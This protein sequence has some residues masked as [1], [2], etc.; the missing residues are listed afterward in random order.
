MEK[1]LNHKSL[2]SIALTQYQIDEIQLL[3]DKLGSVDMRRLPDFLIYSDHDLSISERYIKSRQIGC[4]VTLEKFQ[5]R[6][7][8]QHGTFRWE[9]YKKRQSYTNTLEYKEKI[10]GFTKDDFDEYNKGRAVTE[11]NLIK[12]YGEDI[13]KTRWEE[14]KKRQSY[15]NTLE[16]NI[17]K[18]GY[19]NGVANYKRICSEKALNYKN[20]MR[21][22]DNDEC[23][24][25]KW[26]EVVN[27]KS[28]YF[29]RSKI[30]DELFSL[31]S[32]QFTQCK[33][34]YGDNEFGVYCKPLEKYTKFDYVNFDAN[35]CIEYHGDH[36]HGNPRIYRP[37][38]LLKGKGCT[39]IMAKDKWLED[40][41]KQNY[42]FNERGIDV[43]IIWD[44]DYRN[45]KQETIDKLVKVI[46]D[47]L[48]K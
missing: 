1:I 38:D 26:L 4:K 12:K 17:E 45:N 37:T 7:G 11:F 47:R 28:N 15:T 20:A 43:I 40:E 44:S 8:I 5:L 14:Y 36:Y 27:T 33:Q 32:L 35:I 25:I 34:Y 19:D 10:L 46:N 13:G 6:Y 30:A 18:F 24:A 39:H 22:H 16:Y 41:T 2:R 3:C 21:L 29:G 48:H 31:L 9:E 42:L 23:A